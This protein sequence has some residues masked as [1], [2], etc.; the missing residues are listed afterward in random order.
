[1]NVDV[2]VI[3][4]GDTRVGELF[5]YAPPNSPPVIRFVANEAYAATPPA[6]AVVLS[7]SMRAEQ[8]EQ[9]RAIWHDVLNP[10]FNGVIGTHGDFQLPPWFQGLLPEGIFRNHVADAAGCDPLDHF[11]MLIAC[12]LDLPG[13]VT[14]KWEPLPRLAL[15]RL[16]TQ[17]QDALEMT[18]SAEPV[19]DAVSIS[20]VQPKVAVTR[21][22]SGRYVGRTRLQ[23]TYVIAK[24]PAVGYPRMPEVEHLS[25]LMARA[26]GVTT[27]EHRLEPMSLLVAP[28]RYDLGSEAEGHFL[29]VERFDRSTQGRVHAET[30]AQVLGVAPERK[31]SGGTYLDVAA[32]LLSLPACGEPAVHELLRRLTVNELL[33]NSDAH[34]ANLGLIYRDGR[35]AELSPAYDVVAQCLYGIKSGHALHLAPPR[36]GESAP[37]ESLLSPVTLRDWCNQL[38]LQTTPAAAVVRQTVLAAAKEWPALIKEAGITDKQRKTLMSRIGEH[39]LTRS[40]LARN[41]QLREMWRDDVH[42]ASQ[43]PSTSALATIDRAPPAAP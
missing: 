15:Q 31:Y 28:H 10:L 11:R 34:L 9:Q 33:G 3:R 30:F 21:D 1:M 29:A 25:L 6:S 32:V 38:G 26:A 41:P 20:G 35:T 39:V 2:L 24:L 13:A 14:A 17:N 5:R 19:Q 40:V 36:P 37:R 18:V 12:G 42:P 23:D 7:E 4:V 22:E 8:P 16:V 43:P 27:C